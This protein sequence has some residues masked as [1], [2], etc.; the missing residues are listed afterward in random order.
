M[1]MKIGSQNT[2][3]GF[4]D[5]EVNVAFQPVVAVVELKNFSL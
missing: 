1:M 5:A 4:F 2:L 3:K